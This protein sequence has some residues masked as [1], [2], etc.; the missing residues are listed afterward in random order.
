DLLRYALDAKPQELPTNTRTPKPWLLWSPMPSTFPLLTLTTCSGRP[1]I[2]MSAQRGPLQRASSTP[3]SLTS[4]MKKI[5]LCA[6]ASSVSVF[7]EFE[8]L[9]ISRRFNL[10]VF[11]SP[12]DMLSH[13]FDRFGLAMHEKSFA[14]RM[15]EPAQPL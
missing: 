9:L 5:V 12:G 8:Q 7:S 11:E 4:F 15:F 6:S 14:R 13:A 1:M 3:C 2:R 10:P